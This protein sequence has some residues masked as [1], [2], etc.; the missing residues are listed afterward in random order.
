MH[1]DVKPS[2]V[3]LE[4]SR[5]GS[6]RHVYLSDFGMAARAPSDEG[7]SRVG[8]LIDRFDYL[9]PEQAEDR[10]VGPAADVYAL[11]CVSF[12]ALTGRAPFGGRFGGAVLHGRAPE[13]IEPPSALRAGLP[14]AVDDPVLRAME[15]EPGRRFAAAG[16]LVRAIAAGLAAAGAHEAGAATQA[17]SAAAFAPAPEAAAP[18]PPPPVEAAPPPPREAAPPAAPPPVEAAQPGP[19]PAEPPRQADPAAEADEADGPQRRRRRLLTVT[20]PVIVVTLIA[21]ILG[22]ALAGGGGDDTEEGSRRAPRPRPRPR[23]CAPSRTATCATSAARSRRP[24]ERP[25]S[26]AT[27]SASPRPPTGPRPGG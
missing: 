16:D 26:W 5:D 17:G 24:A 20:L 14:E 13:G 9:A 12:H 10:D 15:Q 19:P 2:N 1:G 11:G 23:R 7:L 18:P 22:Y 8:P 4:W 25:T 6:I 27:P 3:L 21:G